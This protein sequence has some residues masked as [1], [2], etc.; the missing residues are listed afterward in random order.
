[1]RLV[2]GAFDAGELES[3]MVAVVP[4]QGPKANGMP[5]LHKLTPYLGL[6]QNRGLRWRL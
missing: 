6:L 4:F 5:V 2:E 1:M 3:D